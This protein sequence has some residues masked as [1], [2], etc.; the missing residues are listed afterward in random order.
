MEKGGERKRRSK[1]IVN[2]YEQIESKRKSI[3]DNLLKI[4]ERVDLDRPILL[5]E[6]FDV[7]W[8]FDKQAAE[9]DIIQYEIE[10]RKM[11]RGRMNKTMADKYNQLLDFIY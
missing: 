1:K 6:K 4:L 11:E 9:K 7:L 5:K 8:N 10:K 3:N 2:Y